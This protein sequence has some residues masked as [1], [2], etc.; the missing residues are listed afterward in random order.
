MSMRS[1]LRK[2]VLRAGTQPR[3]VVVVCF[4]VVSAITTVLACRQYWVVYQRE[5]D[6]RQFNLHLQAIAIDSAV[7]ANKSELRALRRSAENLLLSERQSA[8]I[9]KDV[10]PAISAEQ[11]RLPVW[12]LETEPADSLISGI[13]DDQIP[14]IPGLVREPRQLSEDL[15]LAR[16][17]SQILP[18][19]FHSRVSIDHA[20]FISTSGLIVTYPAVEAEQITPLLRQFAAMVLVDSTSRQ[21]RDFDAAFKVVERNFVFKGPR[22]LLGTPV[23]F[24]ES[25]R[26]AIIFEIP[27]QRLQD[28]M[29]RT[30]PVEELHALLDERGVLLG[31]N[32]PAFDRKEGDW[33][34]TTL[35]SSSTTSISTLFE[36]HSGS[37]QTDAGLLLYRQLP[38][39]GLMLVNLI[40]DAA[41]LWAVVSQF[42]TLFIGIWI[43]LGLLMAMTLFI[44]DHLLKRE[45]ALNA[46]LRDLGLVDPLTQLANRRRLKSDFDRLTKRLK[47]EHPISLLLLDIDRFKSINDNWGHSA[48][49]EVLRHL[50]ALCRDSVRVQDL[51]ARYGG[52]E[53]CVLLPGVTLADASTRAEAL[54]MAISDSVCV[55]DEKSMLS[56]APSREVRLTV[57]IGVAELLSDACSD[58]D[59]LLAKTDRRLYAAKQNGRNRVISDDLLTV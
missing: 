40:P 45:L 41:L 5:M 43:L 32:E 51:V 50:A 30:T 37:L 59:A 2:G 25:V 39:S 23:L 36:N 56:S 28:Y 55:P 17:M 16:F 34:K 3:R 46:R 54:R 22:L 12:T 9:T 52:E 26:G 7:A 44:V 42:S 14:A 4:L 38:E 58:L 31:S 13:G 49:D 53:F 15:V 19:Q 48:G 21:A 47:G 20:L 8:V 35:G 10:A 24:N 18:V 33:L 11:R 1:A 29:Q 27:Q 57:S 6:A